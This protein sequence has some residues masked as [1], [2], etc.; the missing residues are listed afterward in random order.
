[1]R[2]KGK[3][4]NDG[5]FWNEMPSASWLEGPAW[6]K[7][8]GMDWDEPRAWDIQAGAKGWPAGKDAGKGLWWGK[9]AMWGGKGVW[10]N[11]TWQVP[12]K[13]QAWY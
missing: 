5:Q 6:R 2:E 8:K 13:G 10:G 9:G 3:V 12:G 7:G 1:M 11:R 4:R